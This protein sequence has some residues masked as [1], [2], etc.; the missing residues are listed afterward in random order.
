M[1]YQGSGIGLS[2]VRYLIEMF[3]SKIQIKSEL[4]K[5]CTISFTLKFKNC[6]KENQL[7]SKITN[8]ISLE[9]INVLLIE[10]NKINQ[11]VT[12]KSLMKLNCNVE[13]VENG[14]DALNL[15]KKTTFD[16]ILTDIN[17]P[18]LSGFE[19]TKKVKEL[20]IQTPVFAVTAY[21]YEEIKLQAIESG[22]DE[23]FVKPFKIQE[24][25]AKINEIVR[26]IEN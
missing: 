2:I 23:V 7:I 4:A 25:S 15:L 19:I 26:K 6:N 18:D 16:L 8:Q 24:L 20:N 10:D 22:I 21:S 5:G 13:I 14:F 17:L 3:G 12:Q 1:S 9:P 11:L